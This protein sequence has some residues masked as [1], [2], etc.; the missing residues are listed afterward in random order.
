MQG[1]E[2]LSQGIMMQ[3]MM[4]DMAL[5][6]PFRSE[7]EAFKFPSRQDCLDDAEMALRS[8]KKMNITEIPEAICDLFTHVASRLSLGSHFQGPDGDEILDRAFIFEVMLGVFR[9]L[10]RGSQ[11]SVFALNDDWVIKINCSNYEYSRADAG[12]DW[13]KTCID[14]RGNRFVP[15]VAALHQIGHLYVAVVE[16]LE[17]NGLT[18]PAPEGACFLDLGA[19]WDEE[20]FNLVD[21]MA[22][23]TAYP[24]FMLMGMQA[25]EDL[26]E[27]SKAYC[28]TE[29]LTG[30]CCDMVDFNLMLRGNTPIINDPFLESNSDA[31]GAGKRF[32]WTCDA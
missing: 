30:S 1:Q 2:V 19:V 7:K 31:L 8:I 15:R 17:E 26:I 9:Q 21:Y 13:L 25:G 29:L 28:E 14:L 27:L 4:A 18:Y 5:G 12:F 32:G 23:M 24:T 3:G 6:L 11:A 22:G 20:D 16:R 10:G